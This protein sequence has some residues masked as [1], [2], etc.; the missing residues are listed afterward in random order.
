M[1]HVQKRCNRCRRTVP[2]G[3]RSC[4]ACSGRSFSYVARYRDPDRRERSES[5]SRW[6]DAR[7]FAEDQEPAIRRGE[8]VDVERGR[9]RLREW[10]G[11][12]RDALAVEPST[13]EKYDGIWRLY[14][15]PALGHHRLIAIRKADVERMLNAAAKRTPWQANE[16]LKLTRM[17]LYRAMDDGRLGR[18]PAARIPPRRTRRTQPRILTPPELA[19]IVEAPPNDG[20]LW[21]CFMPIRLFGG[22]SLLPS[23]ETI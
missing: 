8:Y 9:I 11:S 3:A 13:L 21:S 14:V 7:A 12:E 23:S 20:G 18:N 16:A 17:L 6:A 2:D 1:A 10:W 4:A 5:F 15:E 19:A 22:R